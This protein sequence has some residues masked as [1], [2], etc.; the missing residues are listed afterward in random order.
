MALLWDL[1]KCYDTA[2][3]SRLWEEARRLSFPLQTLALSVGSYGWPRK[4]LKGHIAS[5]DIKATRGIVAG[6]ESRIRYSG[7]YT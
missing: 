6:S 5:R 3:L 7:S 4:L 1:H 2:N